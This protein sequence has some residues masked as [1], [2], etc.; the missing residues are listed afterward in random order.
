MTFNSLNYIGFLLFDNLHQEKEQR[1]TREK[2]IGKITRVSRFIKLVPSSGKFSRLGL[3]GSD[4]CLEMQRSIE[5]N[6]G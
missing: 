6:F 2:K 1:T 3:D 5:C 4:R